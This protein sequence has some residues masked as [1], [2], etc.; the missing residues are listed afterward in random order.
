MG[1]EVLQHVKDGIEPKMLDSTLAV[2][3]DGHPQVLENNML[4]QR[5][6]SNVP[7]FLLLWEHFSNMRSVCLFTDLP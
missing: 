6:E 1:A 3:V 5:Y 7:Q 2:T 4:S